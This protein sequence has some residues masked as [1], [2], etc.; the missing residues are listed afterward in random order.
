MI[1]AKVSLRAALLK[2]SRLLL[3]SI[4]PFTAV[5]APAI[6]QPTTPPSR[7]TDTQGH[8]AA[9]CID[10]TG[11]DGLMKGYG[12]RR[13]LPNN[14]ISRAEFAVLMLLLFGDVPKV[15]NA[16]VFADVPVSFWAEGV[17]QK[18]YERGF[19]EGYPNNQFRPYQEISRAQAMT[20]FAK[21][22][23]LSSTG[24]TDRVLSRYFGDQSEIP[25]YARGAIA[26]AAKANLIVNYPEIEQ[27]RPSV[28]MKRGEVAALLC[29]ATEDGY[30]LRKVPEETIV[31]VQYC[32][33]Q[34]PL[35]DADG[36]A[37]VFAGADEFGY[38]KSGM[39]DRSG[40]WVIPADYGE[41]HPFSDGLAL[42]FPPP[43]DYYQQVYSFIDQ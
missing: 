12:D 14:N 35:Y 5:I 28:G 3:M 13:F 19:L 40:R 29:Q 43:F 1:I 22:Q 38:G 20:I 39:Q 4:A 36:F 24:D 2:R 30:D 31:R 42:G 10:R 9:A 32:E 34:R 16:P 41:L 18:A 21:V 27:F 23:K 17:I 33:G 26:A 6:A 37:V 25:G 11:D 8:W 15:R 7:F